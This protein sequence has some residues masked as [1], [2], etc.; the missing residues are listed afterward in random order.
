MNFI[1]LFTDNGMNSP[2]NGQYVPMGNP[3]K[4]YAMLPV[5]FSRFGRQ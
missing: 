3:H 1:A 4:A 2:E 5:Y